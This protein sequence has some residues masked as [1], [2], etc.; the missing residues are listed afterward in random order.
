MV[1]TFNELSAVMRDFAS[2]LPLIFAFK[3]INMELGVFAESK[4]SV[5]SISKG[6]GSQ[7]QIM[8]LNLEPVLY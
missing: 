1:I 3:V 8:D 2:C 7:K 4:L 5:V 6:R